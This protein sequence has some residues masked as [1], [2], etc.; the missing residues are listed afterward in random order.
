MKNL[1]ESILSKTSDKVVDAKKTS[2]E[3]RVVD[4]VFSVLPT[5]SKL[6]TSLGGKA[7]IDLDFWGTKIHPGDLVIVSY[8]LYGETDHSIGIVVSHMMSDHTYRVALTKAFGNG[9]EDDPYDKCTTVNVPS[10]DIIVL[11]H[12]KNVKPMLNLLTKLL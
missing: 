8:D 5:I 3:L 9:N 7:D 10:E 1:S 2:E 12:E 4:H 11:A 6:Y